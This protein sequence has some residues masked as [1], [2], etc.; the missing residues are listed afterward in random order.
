MI[1]IPPALD[2]P[3][4]FGKSPTPQLNTFGESWIPPARLGGGSRN[5]DGRNDTRQTAHDRQ[6][7]SRCTFPLK[8]IIGGRIVPSAITATSL[9]AKKMNPESKMYSLLVHPCFLLSRNKSLLTLDSFSAHK[10]EPVLEEMATNDVGSL[11][12]PGGCTSKLQVLDVSVNPP[13]KS[14]LGEC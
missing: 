5:H 3:S 12:V 8:M 10:V 9:C 11:E 2:P 6:S 14:I 1:F 7:L 13:F 4:N